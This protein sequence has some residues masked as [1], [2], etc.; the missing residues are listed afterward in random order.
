MR[1]VQHDPREVE[2]TWFFAPPNAAIGSYSI[3]ASG[4]WQ[5]L[6]EGPWLG[7]GEVKHRARPWSNGANLWGFNGQHRCGTDQQFAEGLT[8]WPT[9]WTWCCCPYVSLPCVCV[10]PPVGPELPFEPGSSVPSSTLAARR[11]RRCA[12]RLR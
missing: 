2:V 11:L 8:A 10:Q 5:D 9:Q 3:F 1:L 12:V 6:K 4:N 7:P